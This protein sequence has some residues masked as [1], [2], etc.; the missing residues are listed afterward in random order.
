M[1]AYIHARPDG[2]PFYVGKGSDVYRMNR[3]DGRNKYHTNITN[4]HGKSN[5]LK[6]FIECSTESTA[7]DLEKGLIKRL[8]NMG[9]TLAN[10]THGGE[11]VSGASEETRAKMR[12][13]NIGKSLTDGHKSKIGKANSKP[14]DKTIY[15]FFHKEHGTENVTRWELAKKYGLDVGHLGKVVSR[16]GYYHSHKGW[17][18]KDV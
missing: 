3:M 17:R 11:G 2:T 6:G 8:K 1:I 7:F 5:I 13:N 10:M 4:K 18:V 12:A 16:K 14:V 9:F 15:S